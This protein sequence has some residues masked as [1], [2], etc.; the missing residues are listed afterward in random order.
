MKRQFPPPHLPG[1]PPDVSTP[2]HT[3]TED[4][5]WTR[6]LGS[7]GLLRSWAPRG[8][9]SRHGHLT[10]QKGGD[11]TGSSM[12]S[13]GPETA[14]RLQ[15]VLSGLLR[16]L[17]QHLEHPSAAVPA[18]W[19]KDRRWQV[20]ERGGRPALSSTDPARPSLS[21]PSPCCQDQ[22]CV[23]SPGARA[24][25][26]LCPLLPLIRYCSSP[27]SHIWT[28]RIPWTLGQRQQRPSPRS[29]LVLIW[30]PFFPCYYSV[31]SNG[32]LHSSY[33]KEGLS[34]SKKI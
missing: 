6:H 28:F 4:P 10:P 33:R 7:I 22:G 34:P 31:N 26:W 2:P 19:R 3:H 16:L 30:H 1:E 17:G 24:C 15:E 8:L 25:S 23:A 13:F 18:G 29:S 20:P 27:Q 21:L 14:V 9:G 5:G 11:L 12:G 32:Y